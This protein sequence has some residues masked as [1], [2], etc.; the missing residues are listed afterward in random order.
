MLTKSINIADG[1]VLKYIET[2]KFKTNYFSFN[3]VSPLSKEKS[4]YNALIP[5]VLM[6]GCKKYPDQA[7]INKRLQYLYSGEIIAKNE[8]Y[9]EY[10]IIGFKANML[11]DRFAQDTKIT[12]E[13]VSLIC[14]LLFDPLLENGIFTEA[15]TKGEKINLIDMIES[16][17]NNKTRYSMTRLKEEMCKNL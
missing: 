10:Q 6:R 15:Y 8:A 1:V 14:D 2:D 5:L 3:F 12:E 13:T 17:K 16:E 7:E 11:D 4:H 9:G